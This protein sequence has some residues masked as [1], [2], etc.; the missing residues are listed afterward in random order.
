MKKYFDK[1]FIWTVIIFFAAAFFRIF[2][3]DLIEFKYDEAW[4]MY[5]IDAFYR[6]PYFAQY[7]APSSIGIHNFP[8][9][10]YLLILISIPVRNPQYLTFM[11]A[12]LNTVFIVFLYLFVRKYY[13]NFVA[14]LASLIM[15]FSPYSIL[16]SRKIWSPDF[17]IFF[18]I[19]F[20]YFIHKI[21]IDKKEKTILPATIFLLLIIQIHFSG[22]YLALT[23]LIIFF[24][25]KIKINFKYLILGVLIGCIPAIPYFTYNLFSNPFCPDCSAFFSYQKTVRT[26]DFQNLIR[27][28]QTVNGSIVRI[29]F[30]TDYQTFLN[31]FPIIKS[32]HYIFMVEFLI[33]LFAIFYILK[34]K[35]QYLFLL[36]YASII[37]ITYF[38]TKTPSYEYY[39]LI[40]AP[41][42]AIIYALS[43]YFLWDF[44][45]KRF[46]KSLVFILFICFITANILYEVNF[47]KFLSIKKNIARPYGPIFSLTQKFIEEQTKPYMLLPFYDELKNYAYVFAYPP[48]IHPKLGEYFLQ[49]KQVD[50]AIE[51]FKKGVDFNQKYLQTNENVAYSRANLIYL[52]ILTDE[53][54]KAKEQL[55]ILFNED[56]TIYNKLEALLEERIKNGK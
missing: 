12:L 14:V 56:K 36:L 11:I 35:R 47:Y 28:L 18:L 22:I 55:N 10:L 53:Y 38:I 44:L 42:I 31:Q 52:Y 26:F 5:M 32:I 30:E 33:P 46:L 3:L 48:A 41:I 54:E 49:R 29:S 24:I 27:P 50:L 25:L 19:P 34:Y 7:S 21:I 43:F 39:F 45:K 6:Q 9:A 16:F 37:P 20:Y 1:P 4:G 15:A 17:L 23:T 40:I 2:F 51:E 13:G 8:F